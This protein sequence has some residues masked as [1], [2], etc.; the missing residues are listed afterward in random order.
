MVIHQCYEVYTKMITLFIVILSLDILSDTSVV[1][2]AVTE[3]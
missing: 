3:V 1:E 2:E